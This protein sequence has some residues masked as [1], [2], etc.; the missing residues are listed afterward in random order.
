MSR[1]TTLVKKKKGGGEGGIQPY[2][3]Q[4][5]Q[6]HFHVP[7]ARPGTSRK[8]A[9]LRSRVTPLRVTGRRPAGALQSVSTTIRRLE[10]SRSE[11]T[12]PGPSEWTLS[13]RPAPSAPLQPT[14][15]AALP[16]PSPRPPPSSPLGGA[17]PGPGPAAPGWLASGPAIPARPTRSRGRPPLRPAPRPPLTVGRKPPGFRSHFLRAPQSGR[18]GLAPA[19]ETR[20]VE[21]PPALSVEGRRWPPRRRG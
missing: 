15:R 19:T 17:R 1:E 21:G 9:S 14:V 6:N 8:K 2:V 3:T 12:G 16:S 20:E 11:R 13:S 4:L 10:H 18:A 5:R 7:A